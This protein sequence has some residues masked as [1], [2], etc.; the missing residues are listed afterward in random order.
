VRSAQ[1][2]GKFAL[3]DI[4]PISVCEIR[5]SLVADVSTAFRLS[6]AG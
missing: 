1:P 3:I 4:L 5:L 2:N 6:A